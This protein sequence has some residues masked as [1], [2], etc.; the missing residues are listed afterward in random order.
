MHDSWSST[1]REGSALIPN[2]SEWFIIN[3]KV[4]WIQKPNKYASFKHFLMKHDRVTH[5]G[6]VATWRRQQSTLV[7]VMGCCLR[8]TSHYLNQCWLIINE[9]HWQVA[10]GN[11][12]ETV[13][14]ITHKVLRNDI[15][16]VVNT[17]YHAGWCP[18]PQFNIKMT[19]YQYRKIHCG[20]K[21]VVR[22]SYLYNGISYTGK[23]I[24]LYWIRALVP[25]V[26][27]A[28]AGM[29]SAYFCPNYSGYAK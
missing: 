3:D 6:P 19:S 10:E 16:Q 27:M 29:I 18:G 17:K 8:A 22:S 13:L 20:D 4:I 25:G 21:T 26:T 24:S 9:D 1:L 5:C 2:D 11:F 23:M 28:S 14:D 7:Q 12:T 15:F